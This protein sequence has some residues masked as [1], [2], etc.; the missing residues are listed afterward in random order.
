VLREH[1]SH[2]EAEDLAQELRRVGV[3][4][5]VRWPPR[6]LSAATA[7]SPVARGLAVDAGNVAD[8]QGALPDDE[9]RDHGRAP[10]DAYL[11]LTFHANG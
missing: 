10:G 3:E 1:L 8:H 2:W 9:F 7:G 11:L 4:V 5:E 6:R